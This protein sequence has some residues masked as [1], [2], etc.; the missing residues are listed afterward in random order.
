VIALI[1]AAGLLIAMSLPVLSMH[2]GFSDFGNNAKSTHTR[3]AFDLLKEGFG[4]GFNGPLLVVADLSQGGADRL[5]GAVQAIRSTPGVVEV[6]P[7]RLNQAKD[8]AVFTAIPSTSQQDA[9]TSDLVNHLRNDV[10]P[11]ALKGSTARVL[12][13]GQ[14]AASVDIGARISSRLPLLFVGV[15]GLSFLLLM[16]VFRS[17]LVALKA[18]VMNLLSIGASYGVLVAIFQWGWGASLIGIEKGP[19]E[20]FLPM[21]LFAI[22]FGLSM[23]YEVFLISRIREEYIETRSNTTAV[24]HG[25]AATARVITAAAAIM[26][27][28]FLTF[29]FGDNRVIK[30]FG[31]GLATA[32]FVDATVVRL[33]LVP[34]TMELLGEANWWLPRWLDRLLPHVNLE[35]RANARRS[36]AEGSPVG[37]K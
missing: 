24:N 1:P 21:M 4:P 13:A 7:P 37:G 23:D 14:T 32:I 35:G 26:V 3:R 22:L 30:E 15:I 9:A 12:V 19:V 10:I 17:V 31:I 11:G 18:A 29:V 6:T 5:D 36:L 28:V 8:T 20:T 27:T 33:I 34:A 25:L 2:M 16:M